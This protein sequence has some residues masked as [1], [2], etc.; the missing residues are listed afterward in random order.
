MEININQNI[1]SNSDVEY[2]LTNSCLIFLSFDHIEH[3]NF[4]ANAKYSVSFGSG[5]ILDAFEI[6]F[7]NSLNGMNSIFEETNVNK[8]SKSSLGIL[9]FSKISNLCFLIS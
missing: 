7:L 9:D 4:N 5:Q 8:R 2:T 6:K 1:L 3:F